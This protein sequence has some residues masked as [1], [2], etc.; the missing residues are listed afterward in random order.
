MA[1]TRAVIRGSGVYD[2]EHVISNAELAGSYNA[3][4]ARRQAAGDGAELAR[5]D[6][7]YIVKSS[8]I[9][10]RRVVDKEGI[11][12]AERMRPRLRR[13]AASEVSLQAEIGLYAARRALEAADADP[14]G[15]GLVIVAATALERAYP[16]IAI[17]LQQLLGARQ[18][19]AF[20]MNAA[21]SS[22]TFAMAMAADAI[23]AGT[24]RSAL[25]VSP[26]LATAQVDFRDRQSHFIF[27]DGAAAALLQAEQP[28][29]EATGFRIL[30]HAQHTEFSNAIRNDFGFLEPCFDEDAGATP[31]QTFRQNGVRVMR[32]VVPMASR[33]ILAQLEA[34]SLAPQDVARVWLHQANAHINKLICQKVFGRAVDE[35]RAPS[36]LAERGNLAAAGALAAFSEFHDDLPPG[37]VG[38]ICSFGAGYSVG[39][40]VVQRV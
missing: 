40:L 32:D 19:F 15:L 6:E 34:L 27:G 35:A 21:C 12:D 13:R 29:G 17:E 22:A 10:S 5:V 31:A 26:E 33:H 3:F 9:R 18:A 20:D 36:I 11:L 38:V 39:S 37:A 7:A 24:V 30:G 4:V 28:G 25:V 2:P 14:A 16:A 8:G 23:A 1:G